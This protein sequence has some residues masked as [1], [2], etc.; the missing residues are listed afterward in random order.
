MANALTQMR[1][2][3]S[4]ADIEKETI[5]VLVQW[6]EQYLE[7]SS[8]NDPTKLGRKS[9]ERFL[10]HLI[11]DR[12]LDE[13]TLDIAL[14]AVHFLH[15]VAH[16]EPP[17]WL[18]ELIAER[19]M[20]G[21]ATVL[22]YAEVRRLL[23]H[24]FDEV[25]WLMAGLVYGSGLRVLECANLRMRDLDL[26]NNQVAVRNSYDHVERW[27]P[28]AE[29]IR[30]KLDP[31]LEKKRHKH[32]KDI[33][34]GGGLVKL[35]T[36]MA[37]SHPQRRN[38]W[39][40]QFVFAEDAAVDYVPGLED[41]SLDHIPPRIFKRSLQRAAIEAYIFRQVNGTTLRNSFA[42]HMSVRTISE[43][44][45]QQ[46]LGKKKPPS[47]NGEAVPLAVKGMHLPIEAPKEKL[48]LR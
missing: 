46:I 19:K 48:S 6:A 22:T 38:N 15:K 23:T 5:A 16:G 41:Q 43:L 4:E 12:G 29:N 18:D 45:I 44:E 21:A 14:E 47:Q 28:L 1:N 13:N 11:N 31:Y 17:E 39:S 27:A 2:A 35:P 8:S 7:M 30:E 34:K 25:D 36:G 42:D 37:D 33:I 3:L 10:R 24:L 32:I 9:V 40:W 20:H 26:D